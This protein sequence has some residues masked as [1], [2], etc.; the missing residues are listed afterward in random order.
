M[1]AN[2]PRLRSDLTVSEQ[3]T[4]GA[5]CVVIKDPLTS[6][7]FRFGE[8]EQFI[9]QQCDG[10][11]PLEVIRQRTEQKFGAT[12]PAENLRAFIRNL[13]S[14]GLLEGDET[15]S[16]RA[17]KRGRGR[18]QGRLRGS[19]LYLRVKVA[20]PNR[21][22]DRLMPRVRGFFTPGSLVVGA[23]VILLA[24]GTAA[25]NW[26][27]IVQDF[28]RLYRFSAILPFLAVTFL[29]ASAHEFAHGLTCKYFGG[30]VHELGFMLIYFQPAFYC[31]VS[32]AWL[33]PEKSKRLWVGFA[34][35]YFELLLWALAV[36]AWRLTEADTVVN[37]VA[38]I[39]MA[40]SGV[41]TLLNLSPL[42]KLDGYYML[43]DYLDLPNLRRRSFR[44]LGNRLKKLT[45][46]TDHPEEPSARERRLYLTYGLLAAVPSLALL[47]VAAVKTSGFL[48][49]HDRPI[50]LALFA[51]F[52]AA[53][54]RRRVGRLL[55]GKG[56]EADSDDADL[57]DGSVPAPPPP[58]PDG[59]GTKPSRES[60]PKRK[61]RIQALA[62][63]AATVAIVFL[64]H[65]E[66]RVTGPFTILPVRNADVRSEI[67][68]QIESID[69]AEGDEVRA[70]DV[71]ARL[72]DRQTRVE[73]QKTE[74]QIQ[75]ARARL[76]MLEAGTTPDSIAL[77][78]TAVDRAQDQL[79]Y[80]R[81]RL[82]RNKQ[83][84]DSGV[85]TRT[86]LEDTQEAA[87]VA[88][89]DLAEARHKL[90]VLQRG[91]RPEEIAATRAEIS[92]LEGQRRYLEG[93]LQRAVVRSPAAGVVATPT[94]QLREMVG[95]VV[96]QGALIAKVYDLDKL[97]VEIPIPEK[98]I[99]DIHVG[100][101]VAFKARAY[102]NRTFHGTVTS[103][104]TTAENGSSSLSGSSE[105]PSGAEG[106]GGSGGAARTVLVT[107]EVENQSRLLK[108]GMTGQAKVSCGRR[109]IVDL[110]MRR[111]ARTVKVEFWS[112]W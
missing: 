18:R 10:E 12:L 28:S 17:G 103:I 94:R 98:E 48:I 97:T 104:A 63:A 57:S 13:D 54:T 1:I 11:T 108:P 25:A 34:G 16:A 62:L 47:G 76:R 40:G 82:D 75:Q 38:L 95:Q 89:R 19:L 41:K 46:S 78:R 66:L 74:A 99:A 93:Q 37:Y 52:L 83:L 71:V 35:P 49:E 8:T 69:V 80:A 5:P 44:Y 21:L 60:R 50:P 109:S 110:M 45:G 68:G 30:E 106:G 77:A 39:V 65:T 90:E 32:D 67:D 42:L 86:E 55:G 81:A 56:D 72:S 20:D 70:G 15:E 6:E 85:L 7:F 22:F 27:D 26:S 79:K 64:G 105:A 112:W 101:E 2:A 3:R 29:A 107:T 53:K 51:G 73:L 92:G 91:A 33:F 23:A 9:A 58:E 100:Q 84:A 102:P 24:V 14:A 43:S 61:R 88:E 31:N 111:L 96:Q 36:L 87:A 59:G 4:A